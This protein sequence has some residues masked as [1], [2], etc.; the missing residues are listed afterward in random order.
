MNF[1]LV[2][3][4]SEMGLFALIVTICLGIMAVASLTVFVERFWE[5]WRTERQSR[6]FAG[7]ARNLLDHRECDKFLA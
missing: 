3:I 2:K 1:D 5:F 4:F 7:R 6:R